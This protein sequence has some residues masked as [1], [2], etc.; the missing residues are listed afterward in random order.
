VL[1]AAARTA[2]SGRQQRLTPAER[3]TSPSWRSPGHSS[4]EI[5]APSYISVKTIE[6]N[7]AHI[8]R[9]LKPPSRVDR[10]RHRLDTRLRALILEGLDTGR[11]E[12]VPTPA[13]FIMIGAQPRTDWIRD[14][15]ALDDHGFILTGQDLPPAR[16][17]LTRVPLPFE[18]SLPGVLAAGD[19]RNGSIKRVAAAVGEGSV[20]VGSVHQYLTTTPPASAQ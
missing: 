17:P 4:P 13:V 18:T 8:Y 2:R 1:T 16:W 9:K 15:L 12:Q 6:T 3:L 14:A 11:H 20:A 5:T 10:A 7:S 19:V